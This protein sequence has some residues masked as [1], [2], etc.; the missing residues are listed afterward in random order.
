MIITKY[1]YIIIILTLIINKK[2]LF[3]KKKIQGKT[4]LKQTQPK[5][6]RKHHWKKDNSN[7]KKE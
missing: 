2:S 5:R 7:N 1:N 4:D 3:I 6:K